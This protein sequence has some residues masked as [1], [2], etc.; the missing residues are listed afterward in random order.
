VNITIDGNPIAKKRPRFAIFG[1]HTHAYDSQAKEKL[2]TQIQYSIAKKQ[3]TDKPYLSEL[4]LHVHFNFHLPIAVSLPK[5]KQNAMEWGF[6]PCVCA[7][8]L[9]NLEKYY[10]DCGNG[11]LWPDD[12]SIT[13]LSSAKFYSKR[14]RTEII[15]MPKIEHVPKN[16]QTL[17]RFSPAEFKEFL[18]DVR[19]LCSLDPNLLESLEGDARAVWLTSAAALIGEPE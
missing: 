8:D 16:R 1:G 17:E 3:I 2:K 4:P 9:D 7:P 15:I 12:R 6:E 14:P 11:I 13:Q 18:I 5:V 10:L 19:N